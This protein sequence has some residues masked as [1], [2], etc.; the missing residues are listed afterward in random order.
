MFPRHAL[1]LGAG[2]GLVALA[3]TLAAVVPPAADAAAPPQR[4]L[5]EWP[6]TDFDRHSV[7]LDEI[8]S[9]GPPKDGIPSIDDPTFVPV[10]EADLPP[11]E[12]VI[13]LVV[14]G[15]ARA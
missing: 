10:A 4:W 2:G 14:D 6:R 3:L 7:P 12:P 9:G 8:I 11:R 5:M 15:D 1:A 13:G